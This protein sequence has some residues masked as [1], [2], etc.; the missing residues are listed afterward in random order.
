M[1][2]N[3]YQALKEKFEWERA[4]GD[5]LEAMNYKQTQMIDQA[6]SEVEQLETEVH[7]LDVQLASKL[8]V[9]AVLEDRKRIADDLI[10][11]LK[12]TVERLELG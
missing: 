6:W 8:E 4:R 11:N 9:I 1:Q 12:A 7:E 10:A 3:A 2:D 5:D